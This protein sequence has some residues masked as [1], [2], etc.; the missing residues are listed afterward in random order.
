MSDVTSLDDPTD[1]PVRDRAGCR[2]LHRP[3][4]RRPDARRRARPRLGLGRRRGAAGRDRRGAA[5]PRG[6]RVLRPGRRRARGHHPVDPHLGASEQQ[7]STPWCWAAGRTCTRAVAS[8]AWCTASGRL[9]RPAPAT[10][11][12]TNGCGGLNLAWGPGTPVLISDHINLTATSPLEGATFVDLTDLYS[13]RLRAI[14]RE[15][16]PTLDEGV[17]VQFPGP[18]YETP[19]EVQ[20]AGRARRRPRRHVH[21]ARGDRR[22]ARGPGGPR[23]LAR[24]QPRAPASAPSRSA[25]PR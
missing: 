23:H 14:A 17:Y 5:E 15:V 2:G 21:V 3:S 25:T 8:D 18:H 6:S 16:D 24:H 10:V 20:M 22:P 12:L 9:P 13:S 4:D 11:V 1:R 7:P 19:A